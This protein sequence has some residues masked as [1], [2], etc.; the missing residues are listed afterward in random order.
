MRKNNNEETSLGDIRERSLDHSQDYENLIKS[1]RNLTQRSTS[2]GGSNVREMVAS[3]CSSN[4]EVKLFELKF[5][6]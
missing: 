1:G 4:E 5:K 3:G 6:G 2:R